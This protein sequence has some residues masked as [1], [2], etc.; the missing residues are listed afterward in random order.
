VVLPP[1]PIVSTEYTDGRVS[2]GQIK[3]YYFPVVYSEVGDTMVLLNKTQIYGTGENGDTKMLMNIEKDATGKRTYQNWVYPTD[4]R[5]GSE[6]MTG[7]SA[8]P[9]IIEPCQEEI[10]L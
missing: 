2:D 3:Y 8:W 9:E 5:R 1:G 10:A 4:R 7:N 6:S